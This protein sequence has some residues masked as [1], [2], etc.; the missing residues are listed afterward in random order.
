MANNRRRGGFGMAP[1]NLTG[2][3]TIFTLGFVV[4]AIGMGVLLSR[5]V[6]PKSML[7]DPGET[8]ELEVIEEPGGPGKKGLGLRTIKF[9]EC[10]STVTINFMLDKSTSMNELT[11]SGISK[12]ARLQEAVKELVG[13]AKDESIVGIQ[14]FTTGNITNDV[15]IAFYR[16]IKSTLNAKIDAIRTLSS[17]PTYEALNFSYGVMSE[18][19][20]S[21]WYPKDRKM[22]FVFISD[23]AP[24]PGI[25]CRRIAGAD[26]DPRLYTPNPADQIK[27]LGVNVYSLGIFSPTDRVLVVEMENLLKSIASKPE[28][29]FAASS[30]D[31][32]KRLLGQ[33]SQKI[34]ASQVTPTSTP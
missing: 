10:A 1:V 8:G 26:Q 27:A 23:G 21:S 2:P 9:K 32:V 16:D 29:Y 22:N 6:T 33:I 19:L 3:G 14:S 4:L 17:T 24:C 13:D 5:G 7:S 25:G 11:P 28:N 15:P 30:G 34:C 12:F 20:R 31:D 18:T